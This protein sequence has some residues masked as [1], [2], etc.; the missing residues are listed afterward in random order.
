MGQSPDSLTPLLTG[1]LPFI[2]IAAAV[3]AYPLSVLLLRLYRRAVLRSMGRRAG[4]AAGSPREE[5]TSEPASPQPAASLRL[6]TLS[7]SDGLPSAP[8]ASAHCQQILAAP[9]RAATLYALGGVCYAV[10]MAL[11]FL[12]S[13]G[14]SF[15]LL[16]FLMLALNFIWPL[17]LTIWLVA[18]STTRTK[19][20][21]L[22]VYFGAYVLISGLTLILSPSLSVAQPFILWGSLNILPTALVLAFLTRQVRAVGPMVLT[23]LV[24]A[25]T[26]SVALL[27]ILSRN[28]SLLRSLAGFGFSLGLGAVGVFI[29]FILIGFAALSVIGWF[30]VKW[31]R[32]RYERKLISDQSLTL[33]TLW[34]LFGIVY[35]IG[36]SFE[37]PIWIFSGLVAF[38]AYKA[39]VYFGFSSLKHPSPG[40]GARLLLLR[41]FSLGKRSEQLFDAFG[42]HWRY[43]G[44]VHMIAGP[45]LATTTVEPHEFLDFLTG[46]LSRRFIDS[47]ETFN[48]R[49]KERDHQPDHD[50]RFRVN[51]FFCFDDTWKMVLTQL[52]SESD[53]VLMD[54]RGFSRERAGCI[55][56]INHLINSASLER[57]VLLVD[58]TT[59]EPFLQHTIQQAWDRLPASSPNYQAPAPQL[60]LFQYTDKDPQ[61]L[62]HLLGTICGAVPLA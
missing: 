28:Q 31:I 21:L 52:V 14:I 18:G 35:G 25:I 45:D 47:R 48:H 51:D 60:R 9:W 40:P 3:L 32:A 19:V 62:H 27:E 2:L 7:G 43:V 13:G 34:L 50:W 38:L 12:V 29:S 53:T 17:V 5:G 33:D 37:G 11:A 16:R 23:F 46:K 57:V 36:L 56:E 20:M 15:S 22:L 4:A 39:A 41:V 55:F 42:L 58:A 59:D 26:G 6:V 8:T 10:V 1:Q 54:V 30:L 44:S 61:S 24:I 49:L